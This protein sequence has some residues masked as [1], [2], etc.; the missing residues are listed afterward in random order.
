MKVSQTIEIEAVALEPEVRRKRGPM[1]KRSLPENTSVVSRPL[2]TMRPK[3]LYQCEF[4][5]HFGGSTRKTSPS[6]ELLVPFY[7]S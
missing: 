5:L 2:G 7:D 3:K 1:R 4:E 6:F